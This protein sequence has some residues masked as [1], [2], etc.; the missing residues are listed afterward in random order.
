MRTG[1]DDHGQ[2]TVMIVGFF[3]VLGL[4]TAVVVDAS[5]AYLRNQSLNS[6]ADGAALAAVD[7]IEGEQVYHGDLDDLA[8]LDP[9]L[10]EQ[11]VE[12]YLIDVGAFD[13]Y[14][15]LER[16]VELHD[17]RAVVELSAPLRLPLTPPGWDD[18]TGI[19]GEASA[20]VPV[21]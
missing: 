17:A 5:A 16:S 18:S 21:T 11:Y 10:A 12:Q 1:R 7:G 13:A 9:E 15:G 19:T 14:P 3:L 6:L 20:V 2:V 8:E 4:L